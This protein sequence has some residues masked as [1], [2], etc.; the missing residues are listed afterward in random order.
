MERLILL[1]SRCSRL[2]TYDLGILEA[3]DEELASGQALKSNRACL[4]TT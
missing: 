3:Y 4:L 2:L 1:R